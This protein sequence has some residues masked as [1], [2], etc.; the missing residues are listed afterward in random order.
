MINMNMIGQVLFTNDLFHRN[1][2]GTLLLNYSIG[3][4]ITIF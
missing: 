2:N 4:K 1:H 3:I